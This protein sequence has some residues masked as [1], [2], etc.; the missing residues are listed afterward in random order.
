MFEPA[1]LREQ[2][3]SIEESTCDIVRTFLR[4]PVIQTPGHYSRLGLPRY[5]PLR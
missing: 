3:Y 2:A 1:V 4:P 5:A